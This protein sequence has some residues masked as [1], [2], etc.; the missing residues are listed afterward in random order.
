MA[1]VEPIQRG[2]SAAIV[3]STT[4]VLAPAAEPSAPAASPVAPSTET[5][6]APVPIFTTTPMADE[7][8]GNKFKLPSFPQHLGFSSHQNGLNPDLALNLM[9]ETIKLASAWRLELQSVVEQIQAIYRSGPIVDGWLECSTQKLDTTTQILRHAAVADLMNYV[10]TICND[11]STTHAEY[12]LCGLSPD[13]KVWSSPCPASQL[14]GISL[15]IS[16]HQKLQPLLQSKIS[17]EKRLSQAAEEAAKFQGR[18]QA[19]A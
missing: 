10:E 5:A 15:A 4:P 18:V 1:F 11:P 9:Q 13:G 17:L 8:T 16:R 19:I 12:R 14:A 2:N 6:A 3:A 7:P